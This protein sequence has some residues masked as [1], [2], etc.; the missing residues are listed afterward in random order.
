MFKNPILLR[1]M[2]KASRGLLNKL[3]QTELKYSEESLKINTLYKN[4]LFYN[5]FKNG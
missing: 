4:V 1:M 5:K 3:K 2:K